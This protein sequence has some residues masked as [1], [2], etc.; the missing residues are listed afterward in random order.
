VERL[1]SA[2]NTPLV[3]LTA[4][5]GYGK[6]TLLAEWD[7]RDNRP[8]A[9]LS[10]RPVHDDSAF[11]FACVVD[12]IDRLEHVDAAVLDP[13]MTPAPNI[14]GTALPRLQA[15]LQADRGA[16]VLV[17]DDVHRLASDASFAVLGGLAESLPAG[18]QLLLAARGEPPLALGR[19]RAQRSIAELVQADL[20]MTHAESRDLLVGMGLDLTPAQLD[21]LVARTEGWPAALYLA[22]LSLRAG[23]DID[24]GVAEFAGDNRLVV[25]Y[26]RDE[27]MASTSEAERRF[28]TRTSILERMSGSLCDAVLQRSGS[29][30]S[31][32]ALSRSNMLLTALDHRDEWFR[33]H[34]LLREMLISEL[35]RA[36][37]SAEAGLHRRAS[38][39]YAEHDDF[40]HA[41]DHAI[42]A[43][44]PGRAGELIWA[45]V[46]HYG[47]RGRMATIDRWLAC[48]DDA[49]ISSHPSLALTAVQRSLTRGDGEAA[50][51][52][53][54]VARQAS[55]AGPDKP[56]ITIEAGLMLARAAIARDGVM[57]MGDDA[58]AA[59]ELYPEDD[60]WRSL[61]CLIEGTALYLGGAE[62]AGR[63]RLEEA[64]SRGSVAPNIQ[65]LSYAQLALMTM[66]R[67][68][69]AAAELV[70][71]ARTQLDRYALRDY[72]TM[73]LVVG[74]VALF[75]ARAGRTEEAAEDVSGALRLLDKVRDFT[76][77]FE[78]ETRIVLA[79]TLLRLDDIPRARQLLG[80]ASRRL[81]R[82]PNATVLGAWIDEAKASLEQT[83]TEA[84]LTPAELRVL[85]FLPTHLSF[86]EIAQHLY[87]SPNT[88]KT[89]AQAIYRKLGVSARADAVDLAWK[90]GLLD[91]TGPLYLS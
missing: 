30:R 12:A 36:E 2:R 65:S 15:A 4:P 88:V 9:W 75:D 35:R 18:S 38:S 91:E 8:F 7:N 90:A 63:K 68:R 89:Q 44:D 33:Y 53:I 67:D 71:Q 39:W 21:T 24:S 27:F 82:I 13:L 66:D 54:A 5:A 60:P 32:R 79:W 1:R 57:Q 76:P 86:R 11:L 78:I 50:D 3:L 80:D 43:G 70:T 41:I 29:G 49:T 72:P 46:S 59:Y 47:S 20:V 52:W 83:S 19:L 10:I 87:V 69:Q 84:G 85:Q 62:V 22:G 74:V 37:R 31:L 42:T 25:D 6:T 16:F 61:C 56:N 48:F 23:D 45:S 58:A 14:T 64:A 40:D 34:T 26:L 17:F 28:L 51:R 81:Q 73:A 55:E 77:W